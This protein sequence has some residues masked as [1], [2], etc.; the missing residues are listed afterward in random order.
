MDARGDLVARGDRVFDVVAP[1]SEDLRVRLTTSMYKNDQS[2]SN[3]LY[4]GD[5]AGSRYYDVIENT[6]STSNAWSAEIRPGFTNKV[7]AYVV[8]PFVK[9]RGL[10]LF[11]N[12]ETAAGQAST[13]PRLRTWRQLAGEG[14]YRFWDENLYA[15]YRYNTAAGELLGIAND[16]NANRWQVAGGWYVNPMMLLKAEYMNQKYYGF[17]TNDIRN[18]AFIKGFMVEATLAF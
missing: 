17:P 12:I 13:E 9:Y 10:E 6:S 5:R 1:L 2:A 3:T 14:L 7:R 16:V 4:T 15:G 18:G 11:G 8:N